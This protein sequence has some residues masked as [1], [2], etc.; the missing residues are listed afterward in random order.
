MRENYYLTYE[1]RRVI[2]RGIRDEMKATEIA[3]AVGVHPATIYREL[4][5]GMGTT[6]EIYSADT[7]QHVIDENLKRKGNRRTASAEKAMNEKGG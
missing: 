2:E 7:A 4:L 1:E 5:R 3:S 6:G